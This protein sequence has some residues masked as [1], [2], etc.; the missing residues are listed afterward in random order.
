MAKL[1]EKQKGALFMIIAAFAYA[2]VAVIVK[3]LDGIPVFEMIFFRN[4]FGIF[5]IIGIMYRRKIPAKGVNKIGLVARGIAGF[6]S[7]VFY[8]MAV[9]NT[10]IGETVA[11]TNTYP[12]L[13]LILSA[14]FLKEKIKNYH[15]IALVLSF[16]GALL[17]I[18]PGFSTIS[19]KY[20]YAII[21][22]VFL[23][24]TYTI[25]KHVRKTDSAELPVL[26]YSVI[27][28]VGSI[29][30]MVF[31]DFVV[32]QGKQ[33]FLLICLGVVGTIYQWF[34]STAYKYAPAGEIS[35]YSYSSIIFSSLL[36]MMFWREYPTLATIFGMVAIIYGAY[37]I[38]RKESR[39][40]AGQ[41]DVAKPI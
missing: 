6:I 30:F 35:I 41:Q 8:Y 25:L 2:M 32:P 16:G 15:I 38:L 23:A 39:P 37:I 33:L 19:G 13:V 4:I 12:F 18:R 20:S 40:D 26:Y 7:V 14:I 21:C 3:T 1:T 34:L 24:I 31:G 17:I 28:I 22:A 9:A 36:G 10:P 29:P 5:L 11:L 27:A